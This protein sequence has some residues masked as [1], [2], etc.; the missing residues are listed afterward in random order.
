[1]MTE[2]RRKKILSA[3]PE[4]PAHLAERILR[5]IDREERRRMRQRMIASSALFAGSLAAAVASV[6][7]FD[8][9]LVRSGFL[10]FLS[11]F[12]TD[13]SFVAANLR[14]VALSLAES[15]PA[16]SAAFSLASAGFVV[17]FASRLFREASALRK[18]GSTETSF[19]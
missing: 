2:E 7:S 15:F 13:F 10:S 5:F 18:G 6:T 17:W 1:M 11:L 14:D 3:S 8:H 12:G 9:D 19:S 16:F 4:P